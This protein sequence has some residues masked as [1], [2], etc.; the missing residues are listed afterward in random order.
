MDMNNGSERL[1]K[2]ETK[3]ETIERLMLRLEAKFD[4]RDKHFVTLDYMQQAL[5]VRDVKIDDLKS[6]L[7]KVRTSSKYGW[8]VLLAILSMTISLVSAYLQSKH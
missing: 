1:A 7:E 3:L 4:E 2:L 8:Q 5:Q 6:D